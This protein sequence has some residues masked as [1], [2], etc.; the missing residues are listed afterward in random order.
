MKYTKA[1]WFAIDYAGQWAIQSGPNYGDPDLLRVDEDDG[2]DEET[3]KAN[4]LLAV[5][6]PAILEALNDTTKVLRYIHVHKGRFNHDGLSDKFLIKLE[7]YESLLKELE[8]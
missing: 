1:P 3:A 7:K 2:V 8:S 6:A 5:N 4:S